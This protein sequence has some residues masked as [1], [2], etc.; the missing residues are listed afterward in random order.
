MTWLLRGPPLEAKNH[1]ALAVKINAGKF[2]PIP[3]TYSEDLHRSSR[4]MLNVD[5]SSA[6][7]SLV[8]IQNHVTPAPL[9]LPLFQRVAYPPSSCVSSR[10]FAYTSIQTKGCHTIAVCVAPSGGR[11]ALDFVC[12][13]GFPQR[14]CLP[15][16]S[17]PGD[18]ASKKWSAC[19]QADHS[20]ASAAWLCGST[21]STARARRR[22]ES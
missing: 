3:S 5:V 20:F 13:Y 11:V 1:L 7:C 22:C 16:S 2:P 19:C 12:L 15:I 8:V 14:S 17:K 6:R 21:N 9:P 10:A 4:W 18:P